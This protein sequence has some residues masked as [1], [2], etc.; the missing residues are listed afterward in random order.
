MKLLPVAL[1]V[2]GVRVLVV[3]GG[4]VAV[5]KVR[6]LLEGG[7]EV[8]LVAPTVCADMQTLLPSIAQYSAREYHSDDCH[9]IML[10]FA[11]TDN[12]QV[13]R[14]IA[15]DAQA[16]NIWCQLADDAGSSALHGAAVVR[17]GDICVGISTSGGSP[18]LAKHLK[19]QIENCIGPEYAQLLELM[20]QRRDLLAQRIDQQHARAQTW[21]AIL[22]SEALSLLRAGQTETA[23]HLIDNLLDPQR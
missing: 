4:L 10:V 8:S 18:A 21:N 5:R 7:A 19:T 20:S 1:K 22:E 15:A 9:K 3:G 2:E 23:T 13:N 16:A 11:C 17:R 12:S 14:Q 6:S